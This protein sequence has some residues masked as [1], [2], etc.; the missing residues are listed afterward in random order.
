M[1]STHLTNN[2]EGIATDTARNKKTPSVEE[3]LLS[4]EYVIAMIALS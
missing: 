1:D 2:L 4:I 3:Q